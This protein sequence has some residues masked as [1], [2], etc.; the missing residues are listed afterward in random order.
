MD[1]NA[2]NSL[3]TAVAQSTMSQLAQQ[4]AT[5][6]TTNPNTIPQLFSTLLNPQH[7]LMLA[8]SINNALA[9][10]TLQQQVAAANSVPSQMNV[11]S[12]YFPVPAQPPSVDIT[13][14]M[15]YQPIINPAS[16]VCTCACSQRNCPVH[17]YESLPTPPALRGP[18]IQERLPPIVVQRQAQVAQHQVIPGRM[19]NT[20]HQVSQLQIPQSTNIAQT[21]QQA[22][23]GLRL[24][25]NHPSYPSDGR[26]AN[27]A[28][29]VASIDDPS[30]GS[31]QMET[32]NIR[33]DYVVNSNNNVEGS[34][35]N[36]S[37]SCHVCLMPFGPTVMRAPCQ[38]HNQ[39]MC[40]EGVQMC[41]RCQDTTYS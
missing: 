27:K 19:P 10:A 40:E 32:R 37:R 2:V 39:A 31:S 4:Q 12:S 6:S 11:F 20:T 9:T 3:L 35:S 29:R 28:R 14:S 34:S 8:S 21:N 33:R 25:R 18:F 1:R 13:Q 17:P 5:T 7:N 36:Y 22:R 23:D 30:P 41:R 26:P 16:I 24:K 15:Y 38:C